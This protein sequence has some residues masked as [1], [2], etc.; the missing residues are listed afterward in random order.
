MVLCLLL[1]IT[2]LK[3]FTCLRDLDK[4]RDDTV[5]CKILMLDVFS[6]MSSIF[7]QETALKF[8]FDWMA[9][10]NYG[11]IKKERRQH[12]VD[13]DMAAALQTLMYFELAAAGYSTGYRYPPS[14]LSSHSL[15]C[16]FCGF[17]F[18]L[19]VFYSFLCM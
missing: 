9:L 6:C 12:R 3:L 11:T 8:T 7:V 14:I 15:F 1:P 17:S 10:Q 5:F 2:L 16:F 19:S 18:P 4:T 13:A